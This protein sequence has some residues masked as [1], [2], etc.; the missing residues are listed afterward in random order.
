[1]PFEEI[2]ETAIYKLAEGVADMIWD[3]AIRW[4]K[5][6]KDSVGLQIV[7]S[8]DSI[9]ANL[10]ESGGR[11]HPADVVNFLYHSRG[12]LRETN[13]WLRRCAKRKL[14]TTQQSDILREKF[15]ELARMLNGYISHKRKRIAASHSATKPLSNPTTHPPGPGKRSR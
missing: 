14:M 9:G 7:R 5:F 13:W 2:E 10:A 8:A 6:A 15:T 1:M 3:I 4:D 12:S 11:F